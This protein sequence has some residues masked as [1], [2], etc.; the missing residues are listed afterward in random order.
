MMVIISLAGIV[1]NNSI[2]LIDYNQILID[3]SV[4][5]WYTVGLFFGRG[6][7]RVVGVLPE[8]TL[9]MVSK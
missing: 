8:V 7:L 2:V 1:F 3:R 9:E 4:P 5:R 6:P